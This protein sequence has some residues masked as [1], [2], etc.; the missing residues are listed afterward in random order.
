MSS[1]RGESQH[2]QS[3]RRAGTAQSVIRAVPT[4]HAPPIKIG[5]SKILDAWVHDTNESSN[6]IFN[7]AYWP[8]D[9]QGSVV[10]V[11]VVDA[12]E[13]AGFLF[14]VPFEKDAPTVKDKLQV[15]LQR[16]G[17][18]TFRSDDSHSDINTR[19]YCRCL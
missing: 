6:V 19:A 14:V 9:A 17:Q 3:R 16:L 2:A 15:R 1:S 11:T 12:P 8:G 4:Q 5:D 18:C 7:R 10:R 13:T